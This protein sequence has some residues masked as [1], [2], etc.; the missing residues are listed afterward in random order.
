VK[1]FLGLYQDRDAARRLCDARRAIPESVTEVG[2]FFSKDQARAWATLLKTKIDH[3]EELTIP[4]KVENG[5]WYGLTFEA[6]E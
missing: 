4:G 1:V 3:V 2:P 5:Q 6:D